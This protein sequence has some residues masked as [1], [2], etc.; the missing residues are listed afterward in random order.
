MT[1]TQ[2]MTALPV[3]K[4]QIRSKSSPQWGTFGVME[5]NG[6]SYTIQGDRGTRNLPKSEA[7]RFW[8]VVA[9]T[10]KHDQRNEVVGRYEVNGVEELVMV[11]RS[12]SGAFWTADAG[13]FGSKDFKT[14]NGAVKFLKRTMG[15]VVTNWTE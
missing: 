12:A 6:D 1:A 14:R 4:C 11:V 3:R 13:V 5:D 9:F 7:V 8:E 10:D 2:I 15:E